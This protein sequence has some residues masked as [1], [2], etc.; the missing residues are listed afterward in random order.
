MAK[1]KL[2]DQV[3][4]VLRTRHYSYKTEKATILWIK[5]YIF[6]HKKKHPQEMGENEISA[7]LTHLAVDGKVSSS[8]QNQA[9]NAIVFLYKH[10]LKIELGEF[11]DIR[12]SKK[13]HHIP[14][15]LS[16]GE[17]NAVLSQ[18]NGVPRLMTSLMYGTGMRQSEC[19]RLRV[20]DI[21][22]EYNQIIIRNSKNN[23]D[24]RTVLPQTLKSEIKEQLVKVKIIYVKD[25]EN[26]FGTSEIQI[27]LQRKY[28]NAPFEWCWQTIFPASKPSVDPRTG[29]I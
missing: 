8:T 19:F 13:P 11:Q 27:A 5:K 9:L 1:I 23:K 6:F 17:V 14:V 22:F 26:Q 10:V 18:M 12:W 7:F 16:T 15:V 25:K 3:K 21:D 24:R 29:V 28:P 4:N 2:L 20:K